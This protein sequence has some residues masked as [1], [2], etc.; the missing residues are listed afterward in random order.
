M[1][2][3][4]AQSIRTHYLSMFCLLFLINPTNH[5]EEENEQINRKP[6]TQDLMEIELCNF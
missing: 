1:K 3:D 5:K 6:I 4:A 2:F